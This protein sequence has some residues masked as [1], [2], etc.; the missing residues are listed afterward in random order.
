MNRISETYSGVSRRDIQTW[1]NFNE[2]H[3]QKKPKFCNKP[4]L[5][6]VIARSVQDQN[7]IDLVN[8]EKYSVHYE[9]K[10][11]TWVLSVLDV[12]SRFVQLRALTGRN[13]SQVLHHLK[14]IY[15]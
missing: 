3:C 12:F 7:Q 2:E 9:G 14:D 15:R 6:P 1:M 4:E 11:Y 5:Q 8:L 10:V 13:S